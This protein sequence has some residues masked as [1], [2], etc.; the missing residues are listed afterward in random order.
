LATVVPPVHLDSTQM[1]K[2]RTNWA[3]FRTR[4]ASERTLMAALRTSLSLIGFGF[5]IYKFFQ[6]LRQTMGDDGPIRVQGP[7]RLGLSLV[8]LGVFVLFAAALQHWLFLKELKKETD[9]KF[10]WSLSLTAAVILAF[11]GVVVFVTILVRL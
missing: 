6:S 8:S 5:T 2:E 1:A 7:R 10:P 3:V 4:L 11:I 9:Q